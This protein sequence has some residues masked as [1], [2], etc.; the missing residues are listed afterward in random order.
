[1][2]I[3]LISFSAGSLHIE[4]ER[5]LEKYLTDVYALYSSVLNEYFNMVSPPHGN[6]AKEILKS[7]KEEIYFTLNHA[8]LDVIMKYV[9]KKR[10]VYSSDNGINLDGFVESYLYERIKSKLGYK[11]AAKVV[12]STFALPF[13]GA[14]LVFDGDDE[15]Y[16]FLFSGPYSG[17]Y[18][19]FTG[20][21]SG[22]RTIFRGKFSGI[23]ATF[24]GEY[25]GK[26]ILLS[27]KHAG[28]GMKV[29]MLEMRGL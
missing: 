8:P 20:K 9:N 7:I 19:L 4:D 28:Y 11:Y 15:A 13:G 23:Y 29:K 22:Q 17:A 24:L 1:M 25:A 3:K 6:D 16:R 18:S 21:F 5:Q 10:A 12:D 2:V 26:D 14:L 27:G